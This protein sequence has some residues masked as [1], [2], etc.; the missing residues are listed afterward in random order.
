MKQGIPA[1]KCQSCGYHLSWFDAAALSLGNK[2]KKVRNKDFWQVINTLSSLNGGTHFELSAEEK[3]KY[4]LLHETQ[5]LRNAL[6]EYLHK[7]LLNSKFAESTRQYLQ[8]RGVPSEYFTYFPMIGFYPGIDP[9]E[10]F[11]LA[12]GFR[13][14]AIEQSYVLQKIFHNNCLIFSYKDEACHTLGFKGR[15]PSLKTKDIKYQKGFRGELKDRAIMGLEC[16]NIAVQNGE[17]AVPLEGEFD[18]LTAQ[19]ECIKLTGRTGEFV[20]FG[21]SDIKPEKL[22]TLKKAGVKLLYFSFDSDTAGKKATRTAIKYAEELELATFT[23][24]LPYGQDPDSFIK[25]RGFSQYR[26]M[27]K[28]ACSAP[29]WLAKEYLSKYHINTKEGLE[30]AKVN[31]VEEAKNYRGLTLDTFIQATTKEL[32][33][34]KNNILHLI[35]QYRQEQTKG[36]ETQSIKANLPDAPAPDEFQ[37]PTS[38]ILNQAGLAKYTYTRDGLKEIIVAPAPFFVS[39]R[40]ANIDTRNEKLEITYLRDKKWKTLYEERS[41]LMD[42]RKIVQLSAKG[43]PVNSLNCKEI[44]NFIHSFE[45]INDEKLPK[46][47]TISGFGWKKEKGIPFFVMPDKA[48]GTNIPIV[49][50]P[51]G[52][53]EEYLTRALRP[54]GDIKEWRWA[55][56]KLNEFPRIMFH[57]YAAFTPP[58]MELLDAPNFII[59]NW[60]LTSIGKTTVIAI[61]ASVWGLPI[62][63]QGGLIVGWDATKV[64]VERLAC[65]FNHL[66]IF[67]DDSQTAREKIIEN[68]LY[69]VANGTGRLRG[70]VKGTQKTS[71]WRTI[72]FSTGERRLSEVT[73]FEGAKARIISLYGSPF[74]ETK[75]SELI[76]KVKPIINSNFGHAGPQF[77]EKIISRGYNQSS[78]LLKK[79]YRYNVSELS[80]FGKDNVSDR[81]AQYLGAVQIAGELAETMFDFGG[82]PKDI[83]KHIFLEN[84]GELKE[85]GDYPQRALESIVSWVQSNQ[86]SFDKS[87]LQASVDRGE[88]FGIIRDGEYIGIFPHKLK[89]ILHRYKFS[90]ST[91]LKA[92][93]ERNWIQTSKNQ[94]TYPIGF[95]G[96]IVRMIKIQWNAIKNLW[97]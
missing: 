47:T 55:I 75:Q 60:G 12:E 42:H 77:I 50:E 21:G 95:R 80:K 36:S 41:I 73:E 9:V 71:Y 31:L 15:K 58:L 44:V 54:E 35:N 88:V 86:N 39:S 18:W 96:K 14:E 37:I 97:D 72:A 81:I 91:I 7:E 70:A 13:S 83:I 92:F 87:D 53:G 48:Y 30:K 76:H 52:I 2:D 10:K 29:E 94:H 57:L 26:D 24:N 16:C 78:E 93:K 17:R 4:E 5:N 43:F 22:Q 66:P 34:D 68:I 3:E 67:L 32:N 89:E 6:S 64:S 45:A 65:L 74:G 11:L 28:N 27:I 90:Y 84:I 1:G 23:I 8:Q 63:E 59:D 33:L 85:T 82:K 46:Q 62:K 61:A 25:S 20:C 19:V 56:R 51:E 49:Y 38:W 40:S 79:E 69:M